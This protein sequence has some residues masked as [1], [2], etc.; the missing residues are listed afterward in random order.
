MPSPLLATAGRGIGRLGLGPGAR[1][2]SL[3]RQARS[4]PFGQILAG[5]PPWMDFVD[6][7]T[8]VSNFCSDQQ[9][10]GILVCLNN[11]GSPRVS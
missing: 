5:Q 1:A 7:S 11:G 4:W 10:G 9:R 3:R 8:S 2:A 6:A